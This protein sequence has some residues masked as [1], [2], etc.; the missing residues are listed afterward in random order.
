MQGRLLQG[1]GGF[2]T[3]MDDSGNRYVL[4]AQRKI[5]RAHM[6]PKIG[7]YVEMTPGEGEEDGAQ[8]AYVGGGEDVVAVAQ[9]EAGEAEVVEKAAALLEAHHLLYL[10]GNGE[11]L[12]L[13]GGEEE[14]PLVE[15]AAYLR[16][17]LTIGGEGEAEHLELALRG[18]I[19][20]G[21]RVAPLM[22]KDFGHDDEAAEEGG[23]ELELEVVHEEK[24]AGHVGEKAAMDEH[25][26]ARYHADVHHAEGRKIGGAAVCIDGAAVVAEGPG[27]TCAEKGE[28][29]LGMGR[30]C[31]LEGV[32][33]LLNLG[34][35]PQVVLIANGDVFAL[36]GAEGGKEVGVDTVGASV[37]DDADER[38][39]RGIL[40]GYG[41]SVVGR[42]VVVDENLGGQERLRQ[43]RVKLRAEIGGTIVGAEDNGETHGDIVEL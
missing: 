1:I 17:E 19:G 39:A 20:G 36:G 30:L 31:G 5:K 12:G 14:F 38:V 43:Q 34:G 24:T 35:L 29:S 41:E 9:T 15:T 23:N 3:A 7:D 37:A 18:E 27:D 25:R 40:P 6:K 16:P 33:L 2:Y 22:D 11:S 42:A 28:R 21:L 10:G 32:H 13:G 4:R 8:S 26:V